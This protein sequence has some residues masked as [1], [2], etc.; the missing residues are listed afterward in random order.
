MQHLKAPA[1]NIGAVILAAT[2]WLNLPAQGKTSRGQVFGYDQCIT[3]SNTHTRVSITEH[4]GRILEYTLDGENIIFL[5]PAQEG[6]IYDGENTFDPTGGRFDLGPENLI[7]K[8]PTLWLGKWS[9]EILGDHHARLTSKVCDATGVQL[10]RDFVLAPNSS[11]LRITQT[12]INASNEDVWWT[13]W[14]RTFAKGG[15]QTIIPLC[16][17]GRFPHK[18]VFYG[19]GHKVRYRPTDDAITEQDGALIISG[20]TKFPKVGFDS[21]SG[22]FTYRSPSGLIFKKGFPTYPLLPYRDIAGITV[23]IYQEEGKIELEA[24]GPSL[25]I[26]P[27]ET[28]SFTEIWTL[29]R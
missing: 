22:E 24:I 4:G 25:P 27:G 29:S 1:K 10:I 5:D 21:M 2:L 8:H 19:P 15:G 26:R 3:L 6:Q 7:P 16:G 17:N 23:S 20:K 14:S 11:E 9:S 18:Y 28:S 13:F 12:M